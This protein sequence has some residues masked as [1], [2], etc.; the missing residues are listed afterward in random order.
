MVHKSF[1]FFV[2]FWVGFAGASLAAV[3]YVDDV[4][5]SG[6]D[7]PAEDFTTI[8]DAVTAASYGDTIYVY[9]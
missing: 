5:G 1:L 9:S 7:N 6:P 3:W 2:A 4:T 8:Q